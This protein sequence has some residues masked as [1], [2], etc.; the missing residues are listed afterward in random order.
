MSCNIAQRQSSGPRKSERAHQARIS[1]TG[2][3]VHR[4]AVFQ[5]T[6]NSCDALA[7][8]LLLVLLHLPLP[9]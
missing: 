7:C 2:N 3:A 8:D 5:D 1:L 6:L 9:C 4:R